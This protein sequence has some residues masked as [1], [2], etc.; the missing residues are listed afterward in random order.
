MRSTSLPNRASSSSATPTAHGL[1]MIRN[2]GTIF[3][4]LDAGDVQNGR[5][6]AV[7][8]PLRIT[9]SSSQLVTLTIVA[10]VGEVE[11]GGATP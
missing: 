8:R 4:A 5:G 11:I 2:G 1:S 6:S 9:L 7:S 3:S 10:E